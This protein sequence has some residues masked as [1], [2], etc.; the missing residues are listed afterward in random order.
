[1]SEANFIEGAEHT[2]SDNKND[3]SAALLECA[4]EKLEPTRPVADRNALV[5]SPASYDSMA[6]TAE[7]PEGSLPPVSPELRAIVARSQPPVSPELRA[8]AEREFVRPDSRLDVKQMEA[9]ITLAVGPLK[10]TA[11]ANSLLAKDGGL[12]PEAIAQYEQSILLADSLR[13]RYPGVLNVERLRAATRFAYVEALRENGHAEKARDYLREIVKIDPEAA[14][15]VYIQRSARDLGVQIRD[16]DHRPTTRTGVTTLGDGS[17]VTILPDNT[18]I[19]V[20]AEGN[21]STRY[22]SGVR[23]QESTDGRKVIYGTD[24]SILTQDPD[25][26]RI[27]T[28]PSGHVRALDDDEDVAY[29][30]R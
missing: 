18:A 28:D 23:V 25:G 20:D 19:V 14:N 21:K 2:V 7:H 24:H 4:Y 26:T 3:S 29:K 30:Y 5:C 22:P 9:L 6:C 1:M 13:D 8:F 12:T 17:T 11:A 16:Q 27:F 15:D 10:H